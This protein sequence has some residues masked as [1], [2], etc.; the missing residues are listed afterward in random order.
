MA[1]P[2]VLQMTST[3]QPWTLLLPACLL[4]CLKPGGRADHVHAAHAN[5]KGAKKGYGQND[6]LQ[7]QDL[8]PQH[9]YVLTMTSSPWF[10]LSAWP[11]WPCLSAQETMHSAGYLESKLLNSVRSDV[12]IWG[13]SE[14]WVI[15]GPL[16]EHRYILLVSPPYP[17]AAD[18]DDDAQHADES[19]AANI[20]ISSKIWNRLTSQPTS[21]TNKS[22]S[23][24][25]NALPPMC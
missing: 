10:N 16:I 6:A 7:D 15:K 20:P 3:M 17:L 1:M 19:A 21:C 9:S 2:H 5:H 24:S 12:Y 11:T 23:K 8:Q 14:R 22:S 4:C 25:R 18:F 13:M